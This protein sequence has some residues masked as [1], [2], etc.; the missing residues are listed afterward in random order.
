MIL[1]RKLHEEMT[2]AIGIGVANAVANITP[3]Q[4]TIA[5]AIIETL[6]RGKTAPEGGDT[7][8]SV[9]PAAPNP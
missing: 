8:P 9:V 6:Q 3:H 4:I 2:G 5:K 7:V 1:S